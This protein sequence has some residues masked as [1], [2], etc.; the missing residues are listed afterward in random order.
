MKIGFKSLFTREQYYFGWPLAVALI[1]IL[2]VAVT[3]VYSTVTGEFPPYWNVLHWVPT[4]GILGMVFCALWKHR[5]ELREL[6]PDD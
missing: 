5:D 1:G 3:G 4:F 6:T 2:A